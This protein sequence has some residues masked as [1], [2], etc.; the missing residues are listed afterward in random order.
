MLTRAITAL[1]LIAIF[2]PLFLIGGNTVYLMIGAVGLLVFYEI[3]SL[4]EKYIPK[5]LRIL[6]IL[7]FTGTCFLD[8][9]WM[10]YAFFIIT[11]LMMI[12]SIWNES[13]SLDDVL[14]LSCIGTFIAV[15]AHSFEVIGLRNNMYMLIISLITYLNDTG[16]YF[17][18]YF[19]GKHKFNERVS[20]KKTWEGAIGGFLTSVVVSVILYYIFPELLGS[21]MISI[22]IGIVLGITGQMGDLMFSLIKRHY[23]VKDYGSIL[24]GHGGALDRID[25]LLVNF[26]VFMIIAEILL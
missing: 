19:I 10:I 8:F 14:M 6:L 16:A 12:I 1:I 26:A 4:R 3:T 15:A 7:A 2:L 23:H 11:F 25:S 18:G 5:V 24:P 21:L 22:I 13:F 17:T 20:P 9:S